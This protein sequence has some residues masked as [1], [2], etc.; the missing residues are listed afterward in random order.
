MKK[1]TSVITEIMNFMKTVLY[2]RKGH[3]R[4]PVCFCA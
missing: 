3:A 4:I 1:H 2:G